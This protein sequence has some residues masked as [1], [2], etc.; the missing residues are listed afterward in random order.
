MIVCMAREQGDSG[1]M[2]TESL[3]PYFYQA[4]AC[5]RLAVNKTFRARMSISP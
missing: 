2:L 5:R 1:T 3:L 4:M